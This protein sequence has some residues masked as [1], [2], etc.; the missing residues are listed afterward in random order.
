MRVDPDIQALDEESR[1]IVALICSEAVPEVE[2]ERRI[3]A[4]R[5]HVAKTFPESPEVFDE[6]YGRRF[7]RLRTRFRPQPHLFDHD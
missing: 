1:T 6:T 5:S 3:R 7:Q 2:I 4:L